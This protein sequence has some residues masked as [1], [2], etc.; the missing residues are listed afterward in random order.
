MCVCDT[1]IA[2]ADSE[3][4]GVRPDSSQT[5]GRSASVNVIVFASGFAERFWTIGFLVFG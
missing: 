1:N 2:V 3:P 5:T 4:S